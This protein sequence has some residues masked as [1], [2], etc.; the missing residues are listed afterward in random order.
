MSKKKKRNTRRNRKAVVRSQP[1]PR[2]VR[3]IRRP[4]YV[5]GLSIENAE[6]DPTPMKPDLGCF[7]MTQFASCGLTS[8][9]E[10]LLGPCYATT[11]G[12]DREGTLL[13]FLMMMQYYPFDSKTYYG[14]VIIKKEPE[15]IGEEFGHERKLFS[16]PRNVILG[17]E[18]SRCIFIRCRVAP[19]KEYVT[20]R[21]V[22]RVIPFVGDVFVH[23]DS[24]DWHRIKE[25]TGLCL[26]DAERVFA[27][28]D[29]GLI[30]IDITKDKSFGSSQASIQR[31]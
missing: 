10:L 15:D 19:E 22:E 14:S 7:L 11:I 2:P 24:L 12:R 4:H 30:N 9:S 3:K 21:T 18:G 8:R 13:S 29:G 31:D 23:D 20:R 25:E 1:K 6:P 28:R 16:G 27:L 26:K 17:P 5:L